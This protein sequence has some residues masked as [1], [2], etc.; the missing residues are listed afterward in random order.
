M[1]IMEN[2]EEKELI[3]CTT[4]DLHCEH[5]ELFKFISFDIVKINFF[6]IM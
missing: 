3:I 4:G 6:C 5:D 1:L 2:I